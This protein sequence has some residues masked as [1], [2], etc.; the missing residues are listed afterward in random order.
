MRVSRLLPLTLSVFAATA[1]ALDSP[2]APEA[3]AHVKTEATTVTPAADESPAPGYVL[4]VSTIGTGSGSVTSDP[5]G[6]DCG[7]TDGPCAAWFPAGSSVVLNPSAWIHDTTGSVF[8]GWGGACARW[9]PCVVTMDSPKSVTATFAGYVLVSV[10]LEG[11]GL[12]TS[13]SGGIRCAGFRFCNVFFPSGETITLTAT[14]DEGWRFE[15]WGGDCAGSAGTC[16]VTADVPRSVTVRFS[17]IQF[18]LDVRKTGEGTVVSAPARL[19]CGPSCSAM[20]GTRTP[21]TL[22]ARPAPGWRLARWTG[23]CA[24][25]VGSPCFVT[26]D[27]EQ[28]VGAI[29]ERVPPRCVVPRLRGRTLPAARK[30]LAAEN[31]KIGRVTRAFSTVREGR[32]IRQSVVAG[33]SLPNGASVSLVVSRGERKR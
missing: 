32:V 30:A 15:G 28:T 17:E 26:V 19:D 21:V 16:T 33:K 6:I 9:V 2:V 3:L 13:Q 22:L 5:P 31:C 27:R 24:D 23:A 4:T 8:A 12:V 25:A 11:D 1:V 10:S 14:P 18:R 29:F 7:E 20:F